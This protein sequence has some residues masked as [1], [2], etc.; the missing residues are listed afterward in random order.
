MAQG[1]SGGMPS[2]AGA[3][4]AG[5]S[6]LIK[7]EPTAQG[8][9]RRL[10]LSPRQQ[11][12]DRLYS[13]YRTRQYDN[14]KVAWDG[15][16]AMGTFERDT[17]AIAG[18]VPPGFY[19][20]NNITLPIRFRKPTAPYHLVKTIVDR[21]SGLLFSEPRHPRLQCEGDPA[22]ED[23]VGAVAEDGRLWPTFMQARGFGGATGTAVVGFKFIA[24]KPYFEAFDP[25]WCIPTWHDR[26]NFV[27]SALEF[28]Y[29]YIEDLAIPNEDGGED[30]VEVEFW[31]RRVIDVKSDTIFKP[32]LTSEKRPK[33]EPATTVQH[34]LG[35]CPVAWIQNMPVATEIDGDPDC[36]GCYEM[37][38]Q[39]DMLNAQGDKGLIAN[40]DPTLVIA[41]EGGMEAVSKGSENALK[42]PQGGTAQYIEI[43][44][45]GIEAAKRKA[46][47]Y[48]ANV[49]EVSQCVL[50]Q[51]DKTQTATEVDRNYASMWAKADLLREQYG[52]LGVKRLINMLIVAVKRLTTPVAKGD[53][54]TRFSISLP[55]RVDPETGKLVSRQLGPGPFAVKLVWPPYTEPNTNDTVQAVTAA[56]TAKTS[57]LIDQET[58]A[59]YVAPYFGV[60]DIKGMMVRAASEA[61]AAQQM[62]E[63]AILS[64]PSPDGGSDHDDPPRPTPPPPP[65]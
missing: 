6:Q 31:Y 21:F 56:S 19:I 44:A 3:A 49:L 65:A 14:R 50:E 33:W 20:A 30:W 36:V 52:E 2:G 10:G 12:L 13:Y 8:D 58:A 22:T 27:L 23:F 43:S 18:Y 5:A 42:L 48:K 11:E 59:K 15:T 25:R 53:S 28:R 1:I 41:C 63:S 16:L 4:M 54:I 39:I 40:C 61:S 47:S 24:G 17:V 45:A 9:K 62:T 64:K 7:D 35:F 29:T 46:E 57:G 32:V 60:E 55:Q 34:A 26:A 37:V 38:E 51:P